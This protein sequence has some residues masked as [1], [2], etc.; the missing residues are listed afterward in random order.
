MELL[1]R[2]TINLYCSKTKDSEAEAEAED[3]LD[4]LLLSIQRLGLA[5]WSKAERTVFDKV[6]SGWQVTVALR[7]A[8]I[9]KATVI[10]ERELTNGA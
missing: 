7:S 9:Y 1:H 2:L 3:L 4:E 10:Q 8:D 6:L 5:S